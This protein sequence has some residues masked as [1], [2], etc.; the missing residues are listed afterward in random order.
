MARGRKPI[1]NPKSSNIVV[2]FKESEL[3]AI[4]HQAKAKDLPV[5]TFIREIVLNHF[6]VN[7]LPTELIDND[8]NQLRI[9]AD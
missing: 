1:N 6:E 3:K 9:E 4:K 5:S 8:P 7:G 2:R